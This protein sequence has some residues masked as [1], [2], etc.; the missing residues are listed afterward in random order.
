[1]ARYSIETQ[2]KDIY[3]YSIIPQRAMMLPRLILRYARNDIGLSAGHH[4]PAGLDGAA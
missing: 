3:L 4:G 1:M 2:R